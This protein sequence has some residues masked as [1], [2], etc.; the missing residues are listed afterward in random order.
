M[1]P[2]RLK[3][4]PKPWTSCKF[5]PSSADRLICSLRQGR[6]AVRSISKK[7]SL[8]RPLTFI[9]QPKRWLAPAI[10]GSSSQSA[11]HP[12]A[13]TIL[14]LTCEVSVSWLKADTRWYLTR[15]IACSCREQ[16]E[17]H[18]VGNRSLLSRWLGQRR[19]QVSAECLWRSMTVLK[20]RY[21]MERTHCG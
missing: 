3:L 6:P 16:P 8:C 1:S 11:V 5:P 20:R 15:P 12:S 17:A 14:L 2:L 13:I 9:T 21:P 18:R 19:Q 7:G 4:L 10:S